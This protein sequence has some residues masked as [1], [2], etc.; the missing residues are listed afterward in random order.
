MLVATIGRWQFNGYGTWRPPF[1]PVEGGRIHDRRHKKGCTREKL[2]PHDAFSRP[3]RPRNG[4]NQPTP[5]KPHRK[6]AAF[7]F[8][9]RCR[10]RKTQWEAC[11]RPHSIAASGRTRGSILGQVDGG[12]TPNSATLAGPKVK[13]CFRHRFD[14]TGSAAM[15][16]K[17]LP[18]RAGEEPSFGPIRAAMMRPSGGA[19]PMARTAR[20]RCQE[21]S[22]GCPDRC[23]TV[24]GEHHHGGTHSV[25]TAG[26]RLQQL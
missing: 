2:N 4:R 6:D 26:P 14:L 20:H 16:P 12:V 25:W 7:D 23:V 1:V 21:T 9:V 22:A 11:L 17:Y 5:A 13:I 8:G 3:P 15:N 24:S 19:L 18:I 10:G